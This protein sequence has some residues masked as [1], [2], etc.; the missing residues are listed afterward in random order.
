MEKNIVLYIGLFTII[1]LVFMSSC[2]P[3]P[4]GFDPPPPTQPPPV[5]DPFKGMEYGIG[6]SHDYFVGNAPEW[7]IEQYKSLVPTSLILI[8]NGARIDNLWIDGIHNEPR[9]ANLD[10]QVDYLES[11]GKSIK[12][13]YLWSGRESIL[14]TGFFDLDSQER[15][16]WILSHTRMIAERYAGSIAMY[17]VV[18]HPVRD[19][20][21]DNYLGTGRTKIEVITA[22]IEQ[23][24]EI[25]PDVLLVINEGGV[26]VD[27]SI[28]WPVNAGRDDKYYALL[29]E[30]LKETTVDCIGFMTHAILGYFD[31]NRAQ[32]VLDRFSS[33]DIPL[34]ITEF[35]I[36]RP[37]DTVPY[38]PE[39]EWWE[40]QGNEY[41]K[42]LNLFS[43]HPL[44]K[45]VIMW[46]LSDGSSWRPGA[47]LTKY[48]DPRLHLEDD[49][50]LSDG[51]TMERVIEIEF[52][53]QDNNKRMVLYEEGGVQRGIS[54]YLD[55]GLVHA[56]IWNDGASGPTFE[57][58]HLY[59]EYDSTTNLRLVH[60]ARVST[61]LYINDEIVGTG[62][63]LAIFP[64]VG[65][66]IGGVDRTRFHDNAF[67]LWGYHYEGNI[68]SVRVYDSVDQSELIFYL[69]FTN[70]DGFTCSECPKIVDGNG[71]FKDYR[72][73]PKP[74]YD[75][76]LT[77]LG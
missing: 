71:L 4:N 63:G 74:A 53:P 55:S 48:N 35:D 26:V 31:D 77:Y 21:D 76:L 67:G 3:P 6:V 70:L 66:T 42:A 33:F 11:I 29:E 75:V 38:D 22:I 47:A 1:A 5:T 64:R 24:R 7:D 52:T 62:E 49:S 32:E 30:L 45:N 20:D 41:D 10:A 43:N 9:W 54:I 58:I 23:T 61:D 36:M 56:Y 17:D 12:I 16:D 39:S 18:N 51:S 25:D 27:N 19:G 34:C 68:S 72:Y 2:L 14:P 50:F 60:H 28:I 44:V 13:H 46:E 8:K 65:L 37:D 15:Y 73:E 57:P 40:V 59:G 69:D